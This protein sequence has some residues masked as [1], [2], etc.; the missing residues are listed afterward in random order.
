[1]SIPV[2]CPVR[3]ICLAHGNCVFSK[4]PNLS[5]VR[6]L[7]LLSRVANFLVDPA[8]IVPTFI[9]TERQRSDPGD[10][11]GIQDEPY[12]RHR[13]LLQRNLN[14]EGG[15]I[16]RNAEPDAGIGV[17]IAG[18]PATTTPIPAPGYPKIVQIA[19]HKIV[20]IDPAGSVAQSGLICKF[21]TFL[22]FH[23]HVGYFFISTFSWLT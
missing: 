6:I 22:L 3:T 16:H 1:M 9:Q 19:Y 5:N 11:D 10:A 7:P 15:A 12:E 2:P 17:V 4:P 20:Q 18:A 14:V 13:I 23:V 21:F 8:S